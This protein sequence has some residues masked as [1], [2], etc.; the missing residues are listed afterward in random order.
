MIVS[1][2]EWIEKVETFL[3][4]DTNRKAIERGKV[5]RYSGQTSVVPFRPLT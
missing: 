2:P 5:K 4:H 1:R 3:E